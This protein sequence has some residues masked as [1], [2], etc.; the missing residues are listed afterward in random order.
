MAGSA[1]TSCKGTPEL[2]ADFSMLPFGV[3][4]VETRRVGVSDGDCWLSRVETCCSRGPEDLVGGLPR[5]V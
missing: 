3:L 4:P 2:L 5:E 1:G